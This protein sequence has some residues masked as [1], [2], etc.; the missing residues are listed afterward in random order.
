MLSR[1]RSLAVAAILAALYVPAHILASQ[2][3]A[4]GP[5]AGGNASGNRRTNNIYVVQMAELPVVSYG[6]GTN[7]LPATKLNPGQKI[8]PLNAAVVQYAAYLDARHDQSLAAV[9]GSR[10]VYDYHYTFN[11]YAAE[12]TDAHLAAIKDTVQ[13]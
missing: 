12:L 7:G 9:G 3:D 5:G 4:Q 8:D 11:G 1:T 6:G 10:K 2:D 13:I